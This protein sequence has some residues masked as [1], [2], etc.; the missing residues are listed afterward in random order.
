M[1]ELREDQ[2]ANAV[3]FLKDAK[4]KSSPLTKQVAFLESKGLTAD[5]I[6]E[7]FDRVKE[8]GDLG[9]SGANNSIS[10]VNSSSGAPPVPAKPEN[11]V[12]FG[13]SGLS[14]RDILFGLAGSA[15]IGYS[16]YLGVKVFTCL[17]HLL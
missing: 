9:S 2:I 1:S 10:A 17:Q 7:A 4:V 8:S 12:S 6:R 14:W 16:L 13:E 5:E 15:G 11:I 3:Q